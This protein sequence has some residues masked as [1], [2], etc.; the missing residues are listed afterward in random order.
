ME[1]LNLIW[2]SEELHIVLEDILTQ[3]HGWVQY[4]ES[5]KKNMHENLIGSRFNMK[6][7]LQV[8]KEGQDNTERSQTNLQDVIKHIQELLAKVWTLSPQLIS[9]VSS[10]TYLTPKKNCST[11]FL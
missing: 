3:T 6:N 4:L 1:C 9:I 11:M 2:K 10:V 5:Q 8:A 7:T